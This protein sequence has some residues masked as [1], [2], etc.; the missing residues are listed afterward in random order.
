MSSAIPVTFKMGLKN[1]EAPEG[2]I[3]NL[4]CELSKAGVPVEWW[5]GKEE[6][7]P[8]GRYQMKLE[9]KI[10]ELHIKNIQPEDVGEYSCIFGDQKTTAEVNVRGTVCYCCLAVI[11]CLLDMKC[12]FTKKQRVDV[13]TSP[14]TAP[15]CYRIRNKQEV[16]AIALSRNK[17]IL[18]FNIF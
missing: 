4:R 1:Q 17:T 15:K 9:G 6:V 2:G 3:V 14:A 13:W 5:K 18:I 12:S 16:N 11:L 10:A 7:S 8:G